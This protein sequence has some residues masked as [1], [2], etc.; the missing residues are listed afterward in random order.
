MNCKFQLLHCLYERKVTCSLVALV[1]RYYAFADADA[2]RQL[3]IYL[4][5][6]NLFAVDSLILY[7]SYLCTP[8]LIYAHNNASQH[9]RDVYVLST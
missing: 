7:N 2:Q 4:F 9:R 5:C 3:K 6:V 8:A 1:D